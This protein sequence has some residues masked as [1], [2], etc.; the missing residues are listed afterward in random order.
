MVLR[1]A[2]AFWVTLLLSSL[3]RVFFP[4]AH[5]LS[6]QEPPAGEEGLQ[7]FAIENLETHRIEQRGIAGSGEVAFSNL[8]LA[9]LTS[10]RAWLLQAETLLIGRREFRTRPAGTRVLNSCSRL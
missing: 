2:I 8:L 1:R 10:Y 5:T 7:Y 3:V 9:P 6:A 4:G